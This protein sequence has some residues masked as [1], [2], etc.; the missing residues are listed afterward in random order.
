MSSAPVP[1]PDEDTHV[2]VAAWYCDTCD[3]QGRSLVDAGVECWN[4]EGDV[5]I[6]AQPS[7]PIGEFEHLAYV[8]VP[9]TPIVGAREL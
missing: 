7:V 4:C 6:T 9:R 8:P 2:V 3:V 5:T 1:V